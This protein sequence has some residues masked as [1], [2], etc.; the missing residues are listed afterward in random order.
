MFLPTKAHQKEIRPGQYKIRKGNRVPKGAVNLAYMHM[1]NVIPKEN[2][3]ITDLSN[4][5]LENQQNNEFV[6]KIM[7]P[8]SSVLLEDENYNSSIPSDDILVTNVFKDEQ[9]LYYI[10]RLQYRIY[11]KK[12]PDIYGVYNKTGMTIVDKNGKDVQR[13]FRFEI[14]EDPTKEKLY[15]VDVF[16]AFNDVESEEYDVIYNAVNVDP[17]GTITTFPSHRERLILKNA[18]ERTEDITE[19][20]TGSKKS[21]KF[22]KANS[23]RPYHSKVY[24]GTPEMEDTRPYDKFRYQLGVEV[25]TAKDRSIFTSPWYSEYVIHKDFF[26][27]Q[28]SEEYVNGY[29]KI[30]N[31]KM[32]LLMAKFVSF[33]LLDDEPTNIRYFVNIDNPNVIDS[34]RIDGSSEV[35]VRSVSRDENIPI[36]LLPEAMR[37]IRKPVEKSSNV[38]F[39]IRPLRAAENETAYITFVMDNS[40]SMAFNDSDKIIRYEILQSV[41]Y[42]AQ[43]YYEKNFMNISYFANFGYKIRDEFETGDVDIVD[44]YEE[45]APLDN[46]VTRPAQGLDYGMKLIDPVPASHVIDGKPQY[47][48]KFI[49]MATDG[50]YDEENF[51][52]L[53]AKM[54]ELKGKGIRL[55]LITFH[56]IIELTALC[57]KYGFICIDGTK[58]GLAMRLRYV[59]FSFG[60]L[61]DGVT[62]Y[63]KKPF[64][65]SPIDNDKYL[66]LLNETLFDGYVPGYALAEPDRFGIDIFLDRTPYEPE[67]TLYVQENVLKQTIGTY[68]GDYIIKLS[69]LQRGISY[70]LYAVSN[71]YRYFISHLYSIRHNDRKKIKL[72]MPRSTSQKESWYARIQNGRFDREI[73]NKA[74]RPIEIFSIPEYYRQKFT[75]FG[76]PIARKIDERA[77][78]VNDTTIR[79]TH[80][81]FVI[82]KGVPEKE[83]V[84]MVNGSRMSIS[85]W[86]SFNGLVE[87]NGVISESDDIKVSYAYEEESYIYRG[88]YDEDKK[89]FW[90]LDLNPTKGHYV[91]YLDPVDNVVKDVPTFYLI[92]KVVYFY[93]KAAAFSELDANGVVK[94]VTK[95]NRYTIIHTFEK[96]EHP[97]LLLIGEIR[98]RPNSSRDNIRLYDSRI[99]GGGLDESITLDEIKQ[100][101]EESAFYWDIGH[102]D[103]QPFPENGIIVVRVTRNVLKE[104]GGRFTKVDVEE[105]VNKHL[106]YGVLPIIEYLDDPDI[107]IAMPTGLTLEVH[108]IEELGDVQILKPTFN[109]EVK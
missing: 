58:Q 104:Y 26:S 88:Y 105:K 109:L 41:I 9:P 78:Y 32:E 45:G 4:T 7:Y 92:N 20:L 3:R 50:E 11:D 71:A 5:I 91:T 47:N 100:T 102:W 98:I 79:L 83:M 63:P 19:V 57:D 96:I 17:D 29:K 76:S 38:N 31:E 35:Y 42:S 6:D 15:F 56:N 49:I 74:N 80:L 65:M 103:G 24:V 69:E 64:T 107:L 1:R 13:P 34:V 33:N 106:A 89:R 36:P 75:S 67:L 48:K 2:I 73:K 82:E 16:T 95:I 94:P 14:V 22:Y 37:I 60:G 52:A 10:C 68:N 86:N 84:I 99:R 93:I 27:K 40:E 77:E 61:Y 97:D 90:H 51:N 18:F 39:N 70:D 30:T 72:L 8:S 46:D 81:P 12:G 23:K 108:E 44:V 28:E 43:N 66:L 101:Q 62:L 53:E 21:R 55:C 59:F 54:N 87:L 85:D 25:Q